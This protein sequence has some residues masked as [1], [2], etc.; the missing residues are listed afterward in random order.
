KTNFYFIFSLCMRCSLRFFNSAFRALRPEIPIRSE[1]IKHNMIFQKR[2]PPISQTKL[3][4]SKTKLL[5]TNYL[6]LYISSSYP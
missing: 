6:S 1:K 2:G 4:Y 5:L 3:H